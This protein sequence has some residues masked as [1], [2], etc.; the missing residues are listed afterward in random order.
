M[1][2]Y[3]CPYCGEITDTSNFVKSWRFQSPKGGKIFTAKIFKCENCGKKFR[4]VESKDDPFIGNK[5]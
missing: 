3:W 5:Q 2:S 1:K 4:I